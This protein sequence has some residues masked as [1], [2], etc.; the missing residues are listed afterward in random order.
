MSALYR[1]D[2]SIQGAHSVTR[3]VADE[4]ERAWKG[5]DPGGIV[6]RRDLVSTPLSPVMWQNALTAMEAGVSTSETE[7]ATTLARQLADE[8]VAS[9]VI[10]IGAP[11]YNWG[12]TPHMVCWIDLLWTDP[13]FAPRTYPLAGK[14]VV[15]VTA[16]GGDG[17]A[18]GGR[19]GWD[20]SVPYLQR[21]FGPDVFGG[22]LT[23]IETP[24]TLADHNPRMTSL[25]EKAAELRAQSL[26]R[27]NQL[28]RSLGLEAD[29]M[30]VR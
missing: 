17:S 10:L 1:V 15:L 19:D 18:G 14:P 5:A 4:F 29:A 13:R 24:L 23:L 8:M 22:N 7:P 26:A 12:P 21:T 20:N 25:R 27:A 30:K 2:S 9:D 6:T 3:Q 11:L 16:R 28:G